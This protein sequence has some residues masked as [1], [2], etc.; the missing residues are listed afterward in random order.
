MAD[1]RSEKLR[2]QRKPGHYDAV[3]LV[4]PITMA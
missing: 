4:I 1:L 3:E 2:W